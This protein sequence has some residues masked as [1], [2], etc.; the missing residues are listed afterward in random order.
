MLYEEER[1]FPR[2]EGLRYNLTTIQGCA[3][4]NNNNNMLVDVQHLLKDV[5]YMLKGA[6]HMLKDM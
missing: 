2:G 1:I 4:Y 5:E 6:H 3:A